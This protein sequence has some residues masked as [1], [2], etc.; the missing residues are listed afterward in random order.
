MAR[1]L[2]LAQQLKKDVA[3]KNEALAAFQKQQSSTEK[4]AGPEGSKPVR[5]SGKIVA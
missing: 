5:S 1:V 2:R 4:E 3:D